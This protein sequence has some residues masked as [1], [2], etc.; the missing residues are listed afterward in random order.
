[1]HGWGASH[2]LNSL[3]LLIMLAMFSIGAQARTHQSK[4][5]KRITGIYQG[6]VGGRK[7]VLEIGA[8]DRSQIDLA[9][10]GDESLPVIGRYF[11][12]DEGVAFP[13]HGRFQKDG[14]LRLR[15][16]D[17]EF[18]SGAKFVL[19]F[20]D[21]Q[22]RG[23]SCNCGDEPAPRGAEMLRVSLRRISKNFDPRLSPALGV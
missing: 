5:I 9:V 22:G 8:A 17:G 7:M 21:G 13:L 16:Y 2:R 1:M 4:A 20:H 10:P 19:W 6:E 11:Y 15:A 18:A 3:G 14:R 23:F 12:R